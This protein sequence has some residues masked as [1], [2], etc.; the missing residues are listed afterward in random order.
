MARRRLKTHNY[1]P[2]WDYDVDD[3]PNKKVVQLVRAITKKIKKDLLPHIKKFEDFTIA[4][5][6]DKD[7]LGTYTGTHSEP[8]ILLNLVEILKGCDEY[9]VDYHTGIETT[10]THELAHAIQDARGLRMTSSSAEK[11]AEDFADQYDRGFIPTL[12]RRKK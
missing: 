1:D 4:Y 8:V 5:I 12:V 11:Q 7:R 2:A 9:E 10:I 3:K 6:K